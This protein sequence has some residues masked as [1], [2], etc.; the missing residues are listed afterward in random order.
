V[1]TQLFDRS[2]SIQPQGNLVGRKVLRLPDG[3]A[4]IISDAVPATAAARILQSRFAQFYGYFG[5]VNTPGIRV[6][7]GYF[8]ESASLSGTRPAESFRHWHLTQQHLDAF[9]AVHVRSEARFDHDDYRRL[10]EAHV[11]RALSYSNLYMLNTHSSCPESARRLGRAD[12]MRALDVAEGISRAVLGHIFQGRSNTHPAPASNNRELA[13]RVL[14]HADRALDTG[15]VVRAMRAAGA[16]LT[17]QTIG[18]TVRRDLIQRERESRGRPRAF[19]TWHEGRRLYYP[20]HLSRRVAVS[21]Y[22][23][24]Q[25]RNRRCA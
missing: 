22:A 2:E 17:G 8:G 1:T 9:A 11:I 19:V 12:V 14:R 16:V 21:R 18:F 6:L 25:R 23:D 24:A 13:V 15:E 7:G 5:W 10:I 4:L 3:A 20:P